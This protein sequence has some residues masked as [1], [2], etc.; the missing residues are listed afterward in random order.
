M[1]VASNDERDGNCIMTVRALLGDPVFTGSQQIAKEV[2]F[3]KFIVPFS[4]SFVGRR[5]W[6]SHKE[7]ASAVAKPDGPGQN[8]TS[9]HPLHR[10]FSIYSRLLLGALC[11]RIPGIS[12]YLESIHRCLAHR[13]RPHLILCGFKVAPIPIT[14]VEG[15]RF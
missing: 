5:T 1:M 13:Q 11:Y 3:S 9:W 8:Q 4:C 10:F 12:A 14:T 2:I 7:L 6:I 15:D